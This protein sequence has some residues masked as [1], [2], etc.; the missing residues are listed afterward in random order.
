MRKNGLRSYLGLLGI[1]AM[2]SS[3]THLDPYASHV[4]KKSDNKRKSKPTP[5]PSGCK[6]FFFDASG[7]YSNDKMLKSE[8]V[9]HCVASNPKNA[10]RKF[11]AWKLK[12]LNNNK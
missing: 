8:M 1:S 4:T 12:M 3:G 9:F 11:N 2:L 7:N 5:V 6:E 10:L